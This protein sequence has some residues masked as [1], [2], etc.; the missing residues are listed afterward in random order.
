VVKR[1]EEEKVKIKGWLKK[2]G[3]EGIMIWKKRWLVM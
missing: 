2:K 3:R 1:K